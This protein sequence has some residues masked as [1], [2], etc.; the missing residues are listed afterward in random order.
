MASSPGDQDS[1]T[2]PPLQSRTHHLG[3]PGG[4]SQDLGS[5]LLYPESLLETLRTCS[6]SFQASFGSF[7]K[8]GPGL[9]F[10]YGGF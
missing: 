9:D 3:R 6:F 1:T 2:P 5:F 10:R 7:P 4:F 8:E